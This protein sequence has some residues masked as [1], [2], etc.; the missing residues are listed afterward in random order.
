MFIQHNPSVKI[1][2]KNIFNQ[3]KNKYGID[4]LTFYPNAYTA[5]TCG[6]A[7][8]LY[9]KLNEKQIKD[10]SKLLNNFK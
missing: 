9:E 7:I 1:S 3:V 2:K 10:I 5:Y 8:P 4:S 6:L